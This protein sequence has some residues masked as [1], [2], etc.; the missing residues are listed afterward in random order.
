MSLRYTI[1]FCALLLSSGDL[2]LAQGSPSA[3][4]SVP[5]DTVPA[6]VFYWV[7]GLASSAGAA[8][9]L[10]IKILWD[11][12]TKTS[13]LSETER[14]QLQQLYSWH[15]QKDADQVP[16]WYTP[17]SWVDL[18]SALRQDHSAVKG[19]LTRLVEQHD[20]VTSDLRQQLRERLE[21]HDRLHVKMLKLA[22]RVQQAVEALAGLSPPI[23]E[24]SLDDTGEE[25]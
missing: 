19:L 4:P 2:A 10:V 24:D 3:T 6:W 9:L 7:L 12:A 17:R 22:V 5:G 13:A 1:L 25:A 21:L 20:G 15:D 16:L 23:I 8:L 14:N 11:K 18:I